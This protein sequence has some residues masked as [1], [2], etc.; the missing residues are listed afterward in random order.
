MKRQK[1]DSYRRPKSKWN[2]QIVIIIIVILLIISVIMFMNWLIEDEGSWMPNYPKAE[3]EELALKENLTN[4]DY[5]TI[6]MQTGLGREATDILLRSQ[7]SDEL[8][9]TLE[10]YQDDFFSYGDYECRVQAVIVH[11]KRISGENGQPV[12]GFEILD[13]KNGDIFIT[14]ATHSLGWQ[15]GHAAIVTDASEGETLEAIHLGESIIFQNVEKWK[16]Y[17]SFI[18]LRLQDYDSV[19]AMKIAEYAKKELLGLPYGL[20]TGIPQKAPDKLKRTQCSHLVWYPYNRFGY[21]IDSDGSW[22]VTPKD[23]ANSEYLEVIQV[24][25]VNPEE[26]WP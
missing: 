10:Q 1:E 5:D 13:I 7:N 24:Y 4:E 23:I 6:L 19:E 22:L 16:T 21:D 3:L 9:Q 15:H 8:I 14:K 25:G 20:L 12:K 11:E 2:K 26:I 17:P 18:Q